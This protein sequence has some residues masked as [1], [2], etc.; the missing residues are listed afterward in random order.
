MQPPRFLEEWLASVL[1]SLKSDVFIT[2]LPGVLLKVG[3]ALPAGPLAKTASH[4][5]TALEN[6]WQSSGDVTGGP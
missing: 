4:A 3:S 1:V 5:L 2:T 6:A